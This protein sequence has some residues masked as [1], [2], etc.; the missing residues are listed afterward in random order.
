MNQVF[1]FDIMIAVIDYSIVKRRDMLMFVLMKRNSWMRKCKGVG[2]ISHCGR[3]EFIHVLGNLSAL[4]YMENIITPHT[5]P[6]VQKL[7]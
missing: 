2:I 3:S 1:S 6:M 5:I 7:L 4:D